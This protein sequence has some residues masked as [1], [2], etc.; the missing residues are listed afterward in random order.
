MA[1]EFAIATSVLIPLVVGLV[2]Y[3][4]LMNTSAS[5]RGATRAGAEYAKANWNNPSVTNVT[6]GTEQQ[7]C[8]FLGLTLSNGSCSPVTPNVTTACTCDDNTSVTP[9]PP[10]G[11]NP[12][13]ANTN[14]GVLLYVTVTATRSFSPILSWA[15]FAFPTTLAETTV[16]RTQ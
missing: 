10:T 7:V 16:I 8:G 12:C 11:T 5:L 1:L 6:T 2:D 9:C 13:A 14:P 4:M 3:G 15:S